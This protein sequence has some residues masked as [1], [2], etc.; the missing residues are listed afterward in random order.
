MDKNALSQYQTD[1]F[2]RFDP[3]NFNNQTPHNS[4]WITPDT[5]DLSNKAVTLGSTFTQEVWIFSDQN[6]YNTQEVIGYS[7]SDNNNLSPYIR[8]HDYGK[9]IWYGFGD[10]PNWYSVVVNDVISTPG[11]Y[12]VAVTFDGSDYKL[13]VNGSEVNNSSIAAGISPI[14]TPVKFIGT[15]FQGKIDEVRE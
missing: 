2:L 1:N 10:G 11:W 7:P 5:I 15:R 13:F 4:G 3:F 14:N 6:G 12:H 8:T 9:S